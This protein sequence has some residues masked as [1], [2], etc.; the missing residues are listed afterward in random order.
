MK[1]FYLV[2]SGS[3]QQQLYKTTSK[4]KKNKM[5]MKNQPTVQ[6]VYLDKL[7]VLDINKIFYLIIIKPNYKH[8]FIDMM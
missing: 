3:V 4:I 6:F 7:Q 1:L 2:S 5:K 8:E